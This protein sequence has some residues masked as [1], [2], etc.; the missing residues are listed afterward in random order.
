MPAG[1]ADGQDFPW[2]F[3]V[4]GPRHD[5][6]SSDARWSRATG[7]REAIMPFVLNDAVEGGA[8]KAR[9]REKN[10]PAKR[11]SEAAPAPRHPPAARADADEADG[12]I[13][14]YE[15]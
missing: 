6:F 5:P 15:I 3:F 14:V 7:F 8:E 4:S 10:P 12:A 13:L 11:V 9:P 1:Q 2:M